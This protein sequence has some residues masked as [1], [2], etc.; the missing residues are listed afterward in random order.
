MT[1]R[2]FPTPSSRSSLQPGHRARRAVQLQ[3]VHAG[4]GAIDDVDVAAGV[5][6]DVVGLDGGLAAVLAVDFYAALVG[7]V[8]D[9]RD[10][11][12]DLLG[13]E[14]IADVERADAG[15]EEGDEGHLL[16]VDGVHALVG[17][18]RAEAAAALAEIAAGLGYGP[19]R[20]HHRPALDRDVGEPHHLPRLLALVQDRLVDDHDDVALAAVLVLGELGY[21]H[22]LHG[23]GRVRAVPARHHEPRDLRGAQIVRRRLLRSLEQFLAV[24]DLQD[25]ALVC[26]VAEIDAVALRPGRDRP[27]QP[28]R[29]PA[30]GAPLPA[31]QAEV[32]GLPPLCR[33]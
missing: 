15:V 29:P 5:G 6:L 13:I 32:A 23:E 16:V 20:Y 25:A 12:A 8:G 18:V 26:A 2:R 7:L 3:D 22:L 14:G 28:G 1:L 9:G 33:G 30:G 10:E 17:G 11:I 4:V 31:R 24:D 27:G 21:R 19:V